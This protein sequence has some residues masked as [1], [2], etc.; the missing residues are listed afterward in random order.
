MK[1]PTDVSPNYMSLLA[2]QEHSLAD[3]RTKLSSE[4]AEVHMG[5]SD[6][7][8]S[9]EFTHGDEKKK[10]KKTRMTIPIV[11]Q[12]ISLWWWKESPS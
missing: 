11:Q 1:S 9:L 4:I 8:D 12:P 5:L 10:L 7:C 3:F 6:L 2:N